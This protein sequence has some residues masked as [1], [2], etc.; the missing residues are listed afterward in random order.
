MGGTAIADAVDAEQVR[1]EKAAFDKR[2]QEEQRESLATMSWP[3]APGG[4][5]TAI[6]TPKAWGK[7]SPKADASAKSS[8]K[9]KKPTTPTRAL[10][11][12]PV[13]DDETVAKRIQAEADEEDRQQAGAEAM[14]AL[15][16]SRKAERERLAEEARQKEDAMWE[17]RNK[18][19]LD[20]KQKQAEE[21]T[22]A[23]EEAAA[24]EKA[25]G[26]RK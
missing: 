14:E 25:D 5:K 18:K 19:S 12:T 26:E 21:F 15:R 11:P 20:K 13:E 7:P 4:A 23:R 10:D 3:E 1:A 2:K 22:K 16:L 8:V 6:A 9:G 24:K 17:E